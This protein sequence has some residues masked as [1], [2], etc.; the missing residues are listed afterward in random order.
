MKKIVSAFFVSAMI[1]S[2]VFLGE[3]TSTNNPLSVSAQSMQSTVGVRRKKKGPVRKTY[4]K[5]KQGTKWTAHKVKRGTKWTAHK[6]KRGTKWTAHKTKRGTKHV[7]HKTK[8]A[9]Y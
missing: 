1:L 6:T 8:K 2:V 7:F 5:A 3:V 4:Y 9:I